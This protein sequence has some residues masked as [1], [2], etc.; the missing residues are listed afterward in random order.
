M[1]VQNNIIDNID[2]EKMHQFSEIM[3]LMQGHSPLISC[4]FLDFNFLKFVG[5]HQFKMCSN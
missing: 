2:K 1:C 5:M 4:V 3:T